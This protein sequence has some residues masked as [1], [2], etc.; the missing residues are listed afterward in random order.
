MAFSSRF[1]VRDGLAAFIAVVI[2]FAL[3]VTPM[4]D[5]SRDL[6]GPTVV[7]HEAVD[8][9]D[10]GERLEPVR[11]LSAISSLSTARVLNIG[12]ALNSA[13]IT[14]TIAPSP[15]LIALADF[16]DAAYVLIEPWVHYAVDVAAYVA[17]WIIP[18][19]G[20]I[21]INQVD[22]VYNFV[23]SL[24]NSG[25]FN[26]TDWL[27]GDGSALK[28]IADWIVDLGLATI[29]L[30]IDEIDSWIPL[31]PLP[32]Y[33]PRPPYADLPEGAFGDFLVGASH[34]LAQVSNGI[35][36]IWEPIKGG[37]DGAVGSISNIL[38]AI[39]WVPFVPL[40]NFEL[41]EG[42]TLI[43]SEGDAIT[44]FAHDLINAGDQ[45]VVDAVH[46]DGL[47]AAT[48]T[49]L[50]TTLASLNARG[51]EAVGAFVDWGRAQLDYLVDLV[52]PGTATNFSIGAPSF[53][54]NPSTGAND[55]V[56][57]DAEPAVKTASAEAKMSAEENRVRRDAEATT[58]ERPNTDSPKKTHKLS[59][60]NEDNGKTA[61]DRQKPAHKPRADSQ[62]SN[63][64]AEAS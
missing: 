30:G 24:I 29:W 51:G 7:S 34:A 22:V 27:R 8:L 28:N 32:I 20:W 36:N 10:A 44:G 26:T 13:A 53:V 39:A 25:V 42:W 11:N 50:N 62:G 58:T 64:K 15:P 49:A 54:E 14:P 41:T 43:A 47:I 40:I 60:G 3:V 55:T 19:V 48:I 56:S 38:D 33:P 23:E 57:S 17:A 6:G 63:R 46:G 16:I 2:A 1:A 52:T 35:W 18:Y 12:R 37:I 4:P 5:T 45:F 31:P 59:E 9:L 61:A 21:V